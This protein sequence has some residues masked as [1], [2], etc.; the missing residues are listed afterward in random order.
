MEAFWF[1]LLFI[2]IIFAF[3]AAPW[4]YTREQWPYR[5]GGAYRYYPSAAA[6]LGALLILLLVWLGLIVIAVPWAAVQ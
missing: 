3:A 2:L 6:G 5:Y 4:G 1:W